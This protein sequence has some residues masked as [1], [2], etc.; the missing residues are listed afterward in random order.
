MTIEEIINDIIK[1]E[2]GYVNDPKDAGGATCWGIT[3]AVARKHGYT[4]NMKDLPKQTAYNIYYDSY[5]V[6]PGFDKIAAV[7]SDIAAE[8]VDT[9][10]NMGTGVAGKF[11]QQ[12]L[13]AFNDGGSKYPD[14][15]VD[16]IVGK[17]SVSALQAFL[18]QRGADGKVVLLRALNS[19][20]GARYIM[21]AETKPQNERFVFGWIKNR[22][23][24]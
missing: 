15:T 7:D 22:V 9:G 10:V 21:L 1:V 8:L 6:A 19:L 12:A 13:N 11:L 5:V 14:L 24:V 2:G 20:Q 17:A 3:E 18:K 4:G 23:V 16:G